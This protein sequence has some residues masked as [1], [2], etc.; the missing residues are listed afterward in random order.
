MNHCIVYREIAQ[1]LPKECTGCISFIK[2]I[3][4]EPILNHVLE[5]DSHYLA[6]NS[7]NT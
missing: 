6:M 3:I 7:I 5:K 1:P 2:N 4:T